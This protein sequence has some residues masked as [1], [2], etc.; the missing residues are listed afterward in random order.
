MKKQNLWSIIPMSFLMGIIA[1]SVNNGCNCTGTGGELLPVAPSNLTA[2]SVYADQIDLSWKDNS[3]NEGG[4]YVYRKTGAMN[5]SKIAYLNSNATSYS[6]DSLNPNTT[7]WYQVAAHNNEGEA[8]SNEVQATTPAK[9][10]ILNHNFTCEYNG[11]LNE[12]ITE[13]EGNAKNNTRETL[14]YVSISA[15]LYDSDNILQDTT[16]ANINDFP[17]GDTWHFV[18][19]P[20]YTDRQIV[21]VEVW[22]DTIWE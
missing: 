6:D 4:F 8:K 19:I 10:E 9:V 18:M 15:R 17:S 11:Y 22:V 21:R 7:Y 3:N 2:T 16:L 12:W 14:S 1:L 5:Y 20:C 13:I